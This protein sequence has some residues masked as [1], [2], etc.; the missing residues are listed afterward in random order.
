MPGRFQDKVVIVTGKS[1]YF[2]HNFP[3]LGS[4]NGIGRATALL[5]AEE[6]ARV[7]VTGRS[8]ESLKVCLLHFTVETL[9]A[10]EKVFFPLKPPKKYENKV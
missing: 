10:P 4:S 6:G 9:I 8:A 7:T 1:L 3:I 5:F 2:F